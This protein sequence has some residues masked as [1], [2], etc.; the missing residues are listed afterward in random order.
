LTTPNVLSKVKLAAFALGQ[1]PYS[2]SV[3]TDSFADR[4]NREYTPF[5]VKRLF[6]AGGFKVIQLRTFTPGNKGHLIL[7]LFGNL[8]S[9]PA[10][11]ARIVP[12]KMRH[13]LIYVRAKKAGPVL[14]RY[15]A[16]LYNLFGESKVHFK[17]PV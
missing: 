14:N 17:I 2:W 11:I 13:R 1:H 12:F 6:K 10:Y 8:L 4:H 5:E 7:R 3:F 9:C 15:P 16:P